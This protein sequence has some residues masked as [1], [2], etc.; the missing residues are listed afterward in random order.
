MRT[1]PAG[2]TDYDAGLNVYGTVRREEPMFS[3]R[4]H[5]ALQGA[6]SLINVGAGAGLGALH[7]F[8]LQ[9]VEEHLAKLLG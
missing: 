1:E 3:A 5:A 4:V 9:L 2:D 7:D 8:E 6:T